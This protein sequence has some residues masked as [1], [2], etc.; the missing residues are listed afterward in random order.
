MADDTTGGGLGDIATSVF[1]GTE[2]VTSFADT[3]QHYLDMAKAGDW[4]IDEETGTHLRG[5]FA[6]AL[7]RLAEVAARTHRLEQAPKVGSDTYAQQVSQHMLA[8]VNSDER[9][10]LPVFSTLQDGLTKWQEAI[11]TA[12]KHYNTADEA[13]TKHFGPFK[14]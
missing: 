5:A 3:A 12:V 6:Y 2:Q 9:S 8:S 13:A 10:L 1:G 4:A 7:K 11:D 14:D